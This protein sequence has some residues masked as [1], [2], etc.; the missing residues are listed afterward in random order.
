ML[1]H[2]KYAHRFDSPGCLYTWAKNLTLTQNRLYFNILGIQADTPLEFELDFPFFKPI[3]PEASFDKSESVGTMVIKIQKATK[4]IWKRLI[5]EKFNASNLKLKIWWELADVYP[6]AMQKY[7]QIIDK[8][9]D[10]PKDNSKSETGSSKVF[11]KEEKE[12]MKKKWIKWLSTF[13]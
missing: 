7:N 6:K 12:A 11:T 9:D 4:G 1:I 8:E 13:Q 10:K 2:L 3:V 5:D